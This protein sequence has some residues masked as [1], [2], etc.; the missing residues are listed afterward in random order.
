MRISG[1]IPSFCT[2][3]FPEY[4]ATSAALCRPLPPSTALSRLPTALCRLLPPLAALVHHSP[5]PP[6]RV[7]GD[8][9]R[10]VG[11]HRHAHRSM[12]R[13][14]GILLP[15]AVRE[16]LI[17]PHRLAVLEGHERDAVTRLGE[18]RAVPRAMERDE[19]A[20]AIAL[21]ELRP[22][23]ERQAIGRPMPRERNCRLLLLRT[24]PHLLAVAP[25]LRCQDQMAE[26]DVMIT[27]G[28]AEVV[29]LVHPQQLLRWLLGAL[30]ESEQLGPVLSQLVAA[31]L[32]GPQLPVW[33]EGHPHSVANPGCVMRPA[34]LRLTR[35]GR[36]EAPDSRPGGEL[37][38]GVFARRFVRAVGH[39]TRVGG[40]ADVY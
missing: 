32:R 19:R 12:L 20:A 17:A 40:R 23:V 2:S 38:A 4:P 31:V 27:V 11:A 39:L 34:P 5:D 16:R 1:L 7:V 35:C 14:R 9:Q 18:R 33:P 6:R 25:I 13:P 28:P 36:V 26:F 22:R 8:V 30:L 29:A 37:G 3:G 24:P 21:R 15:E 10:A